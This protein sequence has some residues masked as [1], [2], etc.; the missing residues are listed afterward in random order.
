[1]ASKRRVS[2]L[3]PVDHLPRATRI[4]SK[5]GFPSKAG[6]KTRF[7]QHGNAKSGK[8]FLQGADRAGQQQA[9]AHRTKTYEEDTGRRRKP[10]KKVFSLQ[11]SLR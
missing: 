4:S 11:L 7:H 9:I 8:L 3:A 5:S 2:S 10:L 6:R 1:M